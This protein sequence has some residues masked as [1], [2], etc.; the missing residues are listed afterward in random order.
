ML[1]RRHTVDLLKLFSKHLSA[2]AEN[3]VNES[4]EIEPDI[5]CAVK[6]KTMC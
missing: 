1:G 6:T 5:K 2:A 3:R 4:A